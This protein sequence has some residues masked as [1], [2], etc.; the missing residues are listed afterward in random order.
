MSPNHFFPI[1][2]LEFKLELEFVEFV[3][4]VIFFENQPELAP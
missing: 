1:R 4:I 3:R 2:Y